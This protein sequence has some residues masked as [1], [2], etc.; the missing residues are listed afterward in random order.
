MLGKNILAEYR[1]IDGK[2]DSIPSLVAELVQL[3][4]DVLVLRPLPA[5]RAPK[6]AIGLAIPPNVLARA[7]RVIP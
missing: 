7:D 1:Y 4:L 2:T 3:K 5:I 6:Q